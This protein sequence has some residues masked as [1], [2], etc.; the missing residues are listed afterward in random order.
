[1][2]PREYSELR[3]VWLDQIERTRRM[4]AETVAAL[5]NGPLQTDGV[6]FTADDVLGKTSRANRKRDN[7][8]D[9]I[10]TAALIMRL[11]SGKVEVPQWIKDIPLERAKANKVN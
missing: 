5:L 4:H 9:R 2:T 3:D 6:L 7:L 8:K 10:D 11:N 1:M